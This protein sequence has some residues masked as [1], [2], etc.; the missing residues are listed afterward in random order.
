MKFK[1][2]LSYLFLFFSIQIFMFT[3]WLH[4]YFGKVSFEQILVFLNFGTKGLWD[5]DDYVIEKFI[6]L[7][8]YFPI[9]L[10]IFIY[11][12]FY[13]IKYLKIKSRIFSFISK[14]YFKLSIGVAFL[15][16]IHFFQMLDIEK[17]FKNSKTSNFIENNY[18][19][20]KLNK[21]Q[22]N[23]KKDLLLIYLESFDENF[24]T[25]KELTQKTLDHINFKNIENS[26]VNNFYETTY[27]NFTIGAI[28]SSQCGIPQKPIGVLDPRFRERTGKH[29]VEVFGLKN[30]LPN[31]ICLGDILKFNGYENI[32]MNSISPNFQA[33][34]IFFKDHNY[35]QIIERNF[36]IKKG[37]NNFN[38]WGKGVNDRIL[39]NEAK[40]IIDKMKI[41]NKNFNLT[42]LTTDT[43]YPGYTDNYCIQNNKK[44]KLDI[45]FT[46]TCTSKHLY[47]F[48][49]QVKKEYKE[50][51]NIIIVG[52]HLYPK[53]SEKNENLKVKSIYNRI[54]N[55]DIK[56][57]RNEMNHYDLYPTILD[58]MKLPYDYKIGL[59]F[60][61]L[62][63]YKELDYKKYKEDLI[64]EIEKKSDFY[65][66]F[67][68]K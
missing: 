20:P 50:S 51:I 18:E 38:S 9:L 30:F 36:F 22:E 49:S 11:S 13:T 31:A 39:F 15:I 1:I 43:H 57:L 27:N 6:Q 29:V 2:F 54:V 62:R 56:I 17:Q 46:I 37:Y 44:L 55:S 28:V 52:D 63:D 23:N 32:F 16:S 4:R 35:N 60:S 47:K 25:K 19:F 45:N 67:W 26:K 8:I 34:N 14:N 61:V 66:E 7:C 42:I 65:Y 48:I 12:I 40:K 10:I 68:K 58:L 21:I 3:E 59:G 64:S 5:T 24:S 33:M 53:S 41:Q